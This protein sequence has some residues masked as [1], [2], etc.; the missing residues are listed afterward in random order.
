MIEQSRSL[1]RVAKNS[2]DA[3]AELKSAL[4]AY[5]GTGADRAGFAARNPVSAA[6]IRQMADAVGDRNPIYQDEAFAKSTVHKGIVAPPTWFHAWSLPGLES[7]DQTPWPN[8]HIDATF[9]QRPAGQRQKVAER[10]TIRDEINDLLAKHGFGSPAVTD[11]EFQ[12]D[13]YLRPGDELHYSPW[14][15]EAIDGPKRTKLG[16]GYFIYIATS[17]RDQNG[18]RVATIRQTYLRSRP[19]P[20]NGQNDAPQV[21]SAPVTPAAKIEE[22]VLAVPRR[23]LAAVGSRLPSLTVEITP[24]LVIAGAIASQ[25]FQDV[26]HDHFKARERGHPDIYMNVIT[27]SG[28]AGRLVTDWAGPNTI[29]RSLK[30]RLGR[31]NYPGDRMHMTGRIKAVEGKDVTIEVVGTNELGIHIRSDLVVFLPE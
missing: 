21:K 13:R 3:D 27:S 20:V 11:M 4:K 5:V 18:A 8:P 31:P 7:N 26:H 19:D 28:L 24:T 22:G 29:I 23:G 15:V 30:L 9:C 10:Y 1:A 17:V 16:A 12:F 6:V 25:D 14:T 2:L